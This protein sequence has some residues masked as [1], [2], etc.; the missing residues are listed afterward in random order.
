MQ[1]VIALGAPD[2]IP[3]RRVSCTGGKS[4]EDIAKNLVVVYPCV[5]TLGGRLCNIHCCHKGGCCHHRG[6]S[7][8][9]HL[10]GT[11]LDSGLLPHPPPQ[12]L[13]DAAAQALRL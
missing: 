7:S 12:A 3:R 10:P 13:K 8:T 6:T 9:S 4:D 2:L 11:C 1:K 5:S